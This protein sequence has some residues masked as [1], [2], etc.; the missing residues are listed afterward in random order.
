ML[1]APHFE[2]RNVGATPFEVYFKDPFLAYVYASSILFFIG[3]YKAF[4]LLTYV[5]KNELFSQRAVSTV[6]AIRRCAFA[7][8][9]L[10]VGAEAYFFVVQRGKEDIAGGVAMGL[11]MIF[12][13]TLV[14]SAAMMFERYLKRVLALS[15][16]SVV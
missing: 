3:L 16:T 15:S 4:T 2:G 13:L 12:M 8:I 11:F 1:V 5:R 9:A 14:G 7:L 6:R 10:V